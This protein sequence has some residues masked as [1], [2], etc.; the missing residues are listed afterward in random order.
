MC[1][2]TLLQAVFL[3]PNKADQV[4]AQQEKMGRGQIDVPSEDD[5]EDDIF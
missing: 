3:D 1:V 5:E 4:K 2:H